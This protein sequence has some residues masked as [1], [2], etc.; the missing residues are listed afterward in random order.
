MPWQIFDYLDIKKLYKTVTIIK[1]LEYCSWLLV[2]VFSFIFSWI[3][4]LKQLTLSFL[5]TYCSGSENILILISAVKVQ[6]DHNQFGGF[7]V[8]SIIFS[9]GIVCERR[10]NLSS[11]SSPLQHYQFEDGS[12]METKKNIMGIFEQ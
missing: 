3:C 10:M 5:R 11:F 8:P 1:L 12:N 2:V 4:L 6:E 9:R 7:R